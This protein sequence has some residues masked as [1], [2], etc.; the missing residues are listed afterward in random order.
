MRSREGLSEHGHVAQRHEV[1][2]SAVAGRPG[3]WLMRWLARVAGALLL[4]GTTASAANRYWIATSAGNWS[5]SAH[6]STSATGAG[7]ATVPGPSD[8]VYF[9]SSRNGNCT[10]NTA[11]NV[12]SLSIGGY[13]G[14]LTQTAGNTITVAGDLSQSSGTFV[15]GT[16]TIDVNG[17]F[18]LSGGAFTSTTGTFS[19]ALHWIHGSGGTFSHNNGTV[20]FDGTS[21]SVDVNALELFS[22]L[23]V[24]LT[25]GTLYLS[26]GDILR[27]LGTLTLSN[28]AVSASSGS[29][30][31]EAQG[32]V[33]VQ[34]A[35]DGGG[36]TLAFTGSAPLQTF[37]LTGATD[38]YDGDITVNKAAGEVRL[39]SDL[40][41]DSG[42]QDLTLTGGTLNLNGRT[43][44]VYY[45]YSPNNYLTVNGPVT[46]AGTGLL[47][48][49][50]YNQTSAGHLAFTGTPT[51]RVYSA[52]TMSGGTFTP[53]L[54][55]VDLDSSFTLSGGTFNAPAGS[56]SVGG[57]WIHTA[58]GT[59]NPNNGTVIFDGPTASVDV[60]VTETFHHLTV[61]L[62][63][64]TLYLGSGDTLR[65]LGNLTLGNGAISASS[66]AATL[67]PQGQV[68]VQSAFDG[69]NAILLFA[70][71]AIQDFDLTGATSQYDGDIV[72]NK[73]GG[74]LNLLSNLTL[75]AGGQDLTLTGGTLNLNGR[76]LTVY[77]SYSPN[78]Y[79]QVNGPVTI[80]GAGT[81]ITY[82]YNQVS[83]GNLAFTGSA[84]LRA[85]GPFAMAGGTFTANAATLDLDSSF[86]LS[87]G[88]F[89]APAGPMSVAGH[90]LHTTGGAFNPNNGTV[91]FD[92]PTA[93]A[94]VAGIE[95]FHHLTVNLSSGTLYL[96][97]GDTLRA[98]G[99][100]TLGNGAI[101]ASSGSATLEAQGH[102][103]VSQHYDGGNAVLLFAGAASQDFNLT[104]ATANYDGDIVMNKG[105]GQVNLLS[106]LT[107][108]A[109]GQD[110]TL[111]A[112]TLN[113]NGRTVTVFYSYS[114]NN[115]LTV[116]GPV[117][118]AGAGTLIAY[119]FGQVSPG[120]LTFSGN[121]TLRAYGP[122]TM[123]GGTFHAN[124]ATLDLDSSFTLS[125]GTFNAPAGVLSV[126]GNWLHTTGG[127]FNANGGTVIFDGPT[128]SADVNS[129]ETF[130]HLTVNLASGT[131]YLASGDTFRVLGN[132]TLGNGAVTPS[133]GSATLEA[134]GQVTVQSAFDGGKASLHFTGA[135][136]QTFNLTGA[137]DRFDGALVVNKTGGQVE[138]QSALLMDSSNQHLTLQAGTLDLNGFPLTVY[139]SYSPGSSGVLTLQAGGNLQLQGGE[140]I[141]LNGLPTLQPGSTVTYDGSAGPYTV[142]N[143]AY[144]HL[145]IIGSGTFLPPG[146]TLVVAGNFTHTAGSFTAPAGTLSVKG[147]FQRSGGAFLH[148]AGTVLLDG[149]SQTL[150]GNT[151]FNHLTKTTTTAATL[152]FP[153]GAT[154]T[155]LGTVTLQGA[156]GNLLSLRSS[157]PGAPWRIAPTGPRAIAFV[158]VQDSHNLDPL[159]IQPASS[160]NAGNNIGWFSGGP[161]STA[162]STVTAQ[163]TLVPANGYSSALVTVTL[164]ETTGHFAAG[165]TVTL[166]KNGGSSVITPASAV[167]TSS[168]VATFRVKN[169]V[170]E[171]TT[172]T[173]TV[174][175]VP[176][177]TLPQTVTVTFSAS[178]P[179]PWY[180]CAW[181]YRKLI[182]IDY[183]KVDCDLVNFPVLIS[184]TDSHLGAHAQTSGNDL[185]FTGEDGQTQL[186][187]EIEKYTAA[188]G[189]LVA[190]VKVP[191][192]SSSTETVLYL[193]YGNPA[194]PNQQAAAQV[195]DN[196]FNAVWHMR[197]D[198]TGPP[199]QIKDSTSNAKHGTAIYMASGDQVPGQIDGSLFFNGS[200]GAV[201]YTGDLVG[202]GSL[203][204][205]FWVKAPTAGGS[206]PRL[207]LTNGRFVVSL[208]SSG[209]FRVTSNDSTEA[210]SATGAWTPGNWYHVTVTRTAAG[211]VNIYVNGLLSGSANQNSGTPVA[212]GNTIFG[213]EPCFNRPFNGY[214]DEFRFFGGIRPP[215]WIRT[216]YRNQ[217]SPSTFY[218][219]VQESGCTP[220]FSV[221]NRVWLDNG[222][223]GGTPNDGIH[224]GGEP[225][226]PGVTLELR[227]SVG[228]VIQTTT[229]GVNGYYRFDNVPAGTGYTVVLAAANFTAGQPLFGFLSSSGATSGTD[230][231]DN[232]ADNPTPAVQGLASAPFNLGPGLQPVGEPDIS[233]GLGA[234]GPGGDASDNLTLDFGVIQSQPSLSVGNRV[235]LDNGQGGGVVNNGLQDGTEP[236]IAGVTVQLKNSSGSVIATATTNP[237]GYYR[238]DAVPAGTDYTVFLPAANFLSGQSLAGLV[239]STGAFAG[240]DRRDN[241][242]D[243]SNPA[244]SGITSSPFSLLPGS[245]PLNEPDLGPGA[246]AHGPAGD[247]NDNLTLDFGF[248]LPSSPCLT[249]T[250]VMAG[251]DSVSGTPGNVRTFTVGN[252]SVRASAFSRSKSDGSWATAYLGRYS[253]G[254]GVT[255]TSESG[256][257]NSHTVDNIG[258]DNF[259]LFE[260]SQPIIVDRV[261]LGYVATDSDLTAWIG[262]F[263]DPFNNH[264]TL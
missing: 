161:I 261:Y 180:D 207:A 99:N 204:Y 82:Y 237:D 156:S 136:A 94:D 145:S 50:Y 104:D 69:G 186:P 55:T 230:R 143:Y 138:L 151:T 247:I 116:N 224:S 117:T 260:F 188:Q 179:I 163:P 165:R 88:T 256:S 231:R 178:A 120:N 122:F 229:T 149:G 169:A 170:S 208:D 155:V 173:A 80:A 61:N 73:T 29:A 23:T 162:A 249:G 255:D 137:T 39:L 62:S 195:W 25:S 1:V 135:A 168:G 6:W 5:D 152:T 132:L 190:W 45:S 130:H 175:D 97:S 8:A 108:D 74:Q 32:N 63:S 166:T 53:N 199:P 139:Y 251:S 18:S 228:S 105:G 85:Y 36:V 233:T 84:T 20:L 221:G 124:A 14:T 46:V 119:Y 253:G 212:G 191:Q 24:N 244:V 226:I 158:N 200:H 157:T 76:T 111:S 28:G 189:S 95:T 184:F 115:Y 64:G 248:T 223:G 17:S 43:L 101:S 2:R 264:L 90:W 227:N 31:L 171:L 210:L 81:L 148:N 58:G 153:A 78:N 147:H 126:A 44:Q 77:Y 160:V 4:A 144:Q 243:S 250:F 57:N 242:I 49:Y 193:Y 41:M 217:S 150:S 257:S 196:G 13:T 83:P 107:L 241:G 209:R 42:G 181:G 216:E 10:L 220:T 106:N 3:H 239:S 252:V 19:V 9:T 12:A 30:T 11:V 133:S 198:P 259:V 75:D 164:V 109:G 47:A 146:N 205:S 140:T 71:A 15:G 154:Q 65:A 114:P 118:I 33:L 123:A 215:C 219:I 87:G 127:T 54:A 125:G 67:E 68:T 238:F 89:V 141:T 70:G 192:L 40:T 38:R 225:G 174:N 51:L 245:L 48:T 52:F 21:P 183:T 102:V 177:V 96:G 103:T 159:L 206:S 93:T 211:V 35:H 100:L 79:L 203:T 110:L 182:V 112:G 56:L 176:A 172:Y 91:I 128:A 262:N 201:R 187:H 66:G 213:N 37:D 34:S 134:Q 113:L 59:F 72:V 258:R 131:L 232:G 234:H 236:G 26:F 92:G 142:K 218:T 246:G 197:E 27:V 202:A 263:N 254:L 98:L 7:G 222:Q 16:S 240:T 129:V 22:H 214:L 194:A 167:T 235:W 86:T 121:A 60:N 185:L